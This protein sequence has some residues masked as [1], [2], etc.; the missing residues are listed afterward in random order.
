MASRTDA[1]RLAR[2]GILFLTAPVLAGCGEELG[3]EAMPT[4]PVNGRVHVRGRPVG[5]GWIEF[6]PVEGTVGLPRSARLEADGTFLADRI[7]VGRVAIRLVHPPV[8]LPC[9]RLFEQIS[10]IRR[11]VAASGPH[12]I[13][14]DIDIDID[15]AREAQT[16]CPERPPG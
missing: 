8:P 1:A 16:F 7:P 6:R 15:L 11:D 2:L 5:G 10:L 14:I 13:D 4:V 12:P 9:G 3:P